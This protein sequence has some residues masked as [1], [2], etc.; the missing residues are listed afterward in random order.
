MTDMARA[1]TAAFQESRKQVHRP[2]LQQRAG[3]VADPR[4]RSLPDIGVENA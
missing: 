3:T 4:L 2:G 1:A